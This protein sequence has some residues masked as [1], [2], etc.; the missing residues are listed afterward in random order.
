MLCKN[1]FTFFDFFLVSIVLYNLKK[2]KNIFKGV[3][4]LHNA[5]LMALLAST[6]QIYNFLTPSQ[7]LTIVDMS[8][9]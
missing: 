3:G 4:G 8:G 6:H 7:K 2:S 5:L 1:I 9:E